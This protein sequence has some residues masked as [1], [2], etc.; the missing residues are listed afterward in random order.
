MALG[1]RLA[2]QLGA[3]LLQLVAGEQGQSAPIFIPEPGIARDAG[4]VQARREIRDIAARE[5]AQLFDLAE[6]MGAQFIRRPPLRLFELEQHRQQHGALAPRQRRPIDFLD[7]RE[8]VFADIRSPSLHRS[9]LLPARA[10]KVSS[11][12]LIAISAVPPHT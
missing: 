7:R 6:L 2:L 12:T 9:A 11:N 8:R 10:P 1:R 3:G 4:G 5:A